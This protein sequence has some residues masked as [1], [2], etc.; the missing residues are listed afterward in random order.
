MQN[1]QVWECASNKVFNFTTNV[2]FPY[3]PII[4]NFADHPITKGIEN[5]IFKFASSIDFTGDTS[6]NFVPLAMTSEKSG[7]QNP[8]LYFDINKK[9]TNASFP[10]SKLNVAALLEGK[11]VGNNQSKIILVGDGDFPV[12]GEGQNAKQIQEDNVNLMV[13]S[14]DW[15]SDDTGLIDLRTKGIT[16]RPL[17]QISDT[18]K[19]FKMGEFLI[20][21]NYSFNLCNIQSSKRKN[22]KIKRMEENYV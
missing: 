13:N 1:V 9:W 22:L 2:S 4:T 15:L 7:T 5:V 8:P 18:K 14:I 10:L 21:D 6:L 20:A 16:S 3:I 17:D 11:I 12:N 19:Y